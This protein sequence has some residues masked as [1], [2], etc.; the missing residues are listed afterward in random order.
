MK[1]ILT[2]SSVVLLGGCVT[3]SK[4]EFQRQQDLW[5]SV[6]FLSG[7]LECSKQ[8]LGLQAQELIKL[9]EEG[10]NNGKSN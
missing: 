4:K 1:T 6:G 5:Q 3:M 9:K 7:Q 10:E 8:L 2:L